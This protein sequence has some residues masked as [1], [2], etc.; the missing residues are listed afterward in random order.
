MVHSPTSPTV[1]V[2]T[3]E[4]WRPLDFFQAVKRALDK[5]ER[6]ARK[7]WDNDDYCAMIDGWLAIH[8]EGKTHRWLVSETDMQGK[9][10]FILPD[11]VEQTLEQTPVNQEEDQQTTTP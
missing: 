7:S 10:W 4:S 9:D 5:G 1:K 8:R 6:I 11:P 2:V 3:R